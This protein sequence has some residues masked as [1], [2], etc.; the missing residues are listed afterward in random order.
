MEENDLSELALNGTDDEEIRRRFQDGKLPAIVLQQLRAFLSGIHYPLA[1]RS[2][3]ILEDSLYQPFA[4]VY[5]THMVPNNASSL[6]ERLAQLAAAIKAVYASTFCNVAKD[7]VRATSY[8]LEE[9]KMAVII[10]RVLG[11]PYGERF[12]PHFS[13]VARSHH[14]YPTAP[15]RAEDGIAAVAVGL[16]QAVVDGSPCLHFCPRYPRQI[17]QLS[18]PRQYL[19]NS[20]RTFCALRLD[21]SERAEGDAPAELLRLPLEQAEGDGTLPYLVST[22]SAEDDALREGTARAGVRLVTLAPILRHDAFPLADV[23]RLLLD[24]GRWGM[25]SPVE[26]EFAVNLDP[27][28]GGPRQFGILQMRPLVL[29]READDLRLEGVDEN[30]LICRSARVLGNGRI[31]DI[32]DVVFTDPEVFDRARSVEVAAEVAAMNARLVGDGVPYLLLGVGRWGFR[33]PWLGILVV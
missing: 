20:Q 16:G 4:G 15:Q 5:A 14:G 6:D 29:H 12:Y 9:E 18:D 2:S 13:G 3:S 24:M 8:R 17:L 26:I 32:R 23:L 25:N 10:Q 30:D 1:V 19:K 7:Y 28:N 11:N 22:Y 31:A 21:R 27:W 33:D